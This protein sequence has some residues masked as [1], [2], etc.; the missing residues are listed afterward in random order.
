MYGKQLRA[1]LVS[2]D[3][4]LISHVTPFAEYAL[5]VSVAEGERQEYR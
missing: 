4:I 1:I 2:R 3:G 5:H